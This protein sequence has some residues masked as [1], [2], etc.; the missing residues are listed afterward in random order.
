MHENYEGEARREELNKR[1]LEFSCPRLEFTIY[2]RER[3]EGSF[4]IYA[5]GVD[6]EGDIFSSD[7]R[8][9]TFTRHFLGKEVEIEYFLDATSME[10]GSYMKGKLCSIHCRSR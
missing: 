5:D 2:P 10:E 7:T 8:M 3:L 4:F 9:K 6:A 1:C